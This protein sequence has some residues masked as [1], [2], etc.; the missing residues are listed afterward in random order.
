MNYKIKYE[1]VKRNPNLQC[2]KIRALQNKSQRQKK[3]TKT[4]PRHPPR[5]TAS[6]VHR[7]KYLSHIKV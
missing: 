6:K 7:L 3:L 2:Y 1:K 4:A 5:F